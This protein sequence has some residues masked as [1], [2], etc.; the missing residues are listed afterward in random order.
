MLDEL[1]VENL[2]IITRAHIEPGA[3]LV[4]VTGET[5]A[6]KTLLL[7]A[8][9]LLRGDPARSDRIGPDGAE[10][11]VEGRFLLDGDTEVA[12]GRRVGSGRS[13]AYLDGSMVPARALGER[14]A[15][16]VS[17]VAQHEH[18]TLGKEPALRAMLDARLDPDGTE[19]LAAYGAGW[20]RLQEI[21]AAQHALGGDRRALE[22]EA[23]LA[24]H[25]AREIEAAGPRPGE[26]EELRARLERMRHAEEIAAALGDAHG[27]LG[28]E[29]GVGDL[30][31]EVVE[32]L[33][34][35][36]E[37][38][39]DLQAVEQRAGALAAD[40]AD[41]AADL[42]TRSEGVEHDPAALE[43]VQQRLSVLGDLRR[44]YG[45]TLDE[46]IEFG[47]TAAARAEEIA[48][49]L[50]RAETLARD[51]DSARSQVSAIGE[52]LAEARRR[53]AKEL[54]GAAA[55]HLR[56]LG[57]RDPVVELTV[58][59]GP[60]A[61]SGT[62]KVT[63]LFASDRELEPGAVSRV[64]SGGELSR[65]VLAVRLAGGVGE[66]PVVAFDE[67][68]AGI[69]GATALAMGEK[70]AA[71]AAGRQVLV[72][73]HL[74]Q[75]AAFADTHLVVDRDGARAGVRR[76]D[77]EARLAE[78]TR[79]LGGLPASERGREHA[80]ELLALATERRGSG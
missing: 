69:G 42:R 38:D 50:E 4:A 63:L 56:E 44:K 15:D 10:A 27:A 66:A 71:L 57:F 79:M 14:L 3:G 21:A 13:R 34:R 46:V 58:T 36:A 52:R 49:L 23:D 35:A 62:D 75:V 45:E 70:L 37:F 6:G 1:L 47:A 40:A 78:L 67:I 19:A 24:A 73:T 54:S 32:C 31:G 26:D 25:Q 72:V 43:E 41:L 18:V 65:L 20:D 51:A 22:R 68:D 30:L 61:A 64:A 12:V 74:P 16:L 39:P 53:A 80:E 77:G 11:R 17:I 28:D 9:R 48:V 5:G 8:L 2:G 60:P 29:R 59:G 55:G 33:R 76:V 7:G